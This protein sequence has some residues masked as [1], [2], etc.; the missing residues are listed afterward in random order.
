[1]EK[2][3]S[4]CI[5]HTRLLPGLYLSRKDRCGDCAVSTFDIRITAPNREPVIDQP[6]LHTIE[7]LAATWLRNCEIKDR[8]VYFGPMGCRTGCYLL[9]FGDCKPEEIEKYVSGAFGF[10][11][12]YEGDIPGAKEDECGNYLEQNLGMAKYYAKKYLEEL[13]KNKRF[14]YPVKGD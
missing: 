11:V 4:F 3:A 1:M 13:R 9:V 12:N 6:A 7:H 14:I 2:I 10:I 8:I 5:D